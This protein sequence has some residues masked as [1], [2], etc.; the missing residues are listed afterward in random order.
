[1]ALTLT[2]PRDPVAELARKLA[3]LAAE[4]AALRSG[5]E[6]A[7]PATPPGP[8]AGTGKDPLLSVPQVAALLGFAPYRV[9]EL[10]RRPVESGGLPRVKI[11]PNVRV[12]QGALDAWIAAQETTA[13][14]KKPTAAPT[15]VDPGFAVH[16]QRQPRR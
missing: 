10:C 11:G 8:P 2:E 14:Y 3:D 7:R 6:T 5:G 4:L 16:R 12:R 9:Y 15:P 13:G 1:M